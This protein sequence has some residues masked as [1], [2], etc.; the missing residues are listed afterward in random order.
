M[1]IARPH[2]ANSVRLT[3]VLAILST[4]LILSNCASIPKGTDTTPVD[5]LALNA[6]TLAG[7][8]GFR[9]AATSQS[10]FINWA[11]RQN[12]YIVRLN[13]PFG[14][15]RV[16]L[17]KTGDIVTMNDGDREWSAQSPERLL[18]Q[19]TGLRV[20]VS[21]MPDWAVGRMSAEANYTEAQYDDSGRLTAFS[22]AGW[23]VHYLRFGEKRQ[24][25]LP[26]KIRLTRDQIILT[27]VVKSWTTPH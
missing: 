26:T 20:P 21:Y 14:K 15:G 19:L 18:Y 16:T 5:P 3:R 1:D 11:Q 17:R 22:Q 13:G 27:L 10:A 2:L 9:Q 6:W 7:K 24:M 12:D 4:L 8:V 23:Q 25:Q